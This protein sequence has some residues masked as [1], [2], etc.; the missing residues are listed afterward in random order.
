MI[1]L[2]PIVLFCFILHEQFVSVS[3]KTEVQDALLK[4]LATKQL[5][6]IPVDE[7]F[8]FTQDGV[9]AIY[10]KQEANKSNGKNILRIL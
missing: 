3:Q 1:R 6:K 5:K 7:V 8:P 2:V 9:R 4:L 10:A